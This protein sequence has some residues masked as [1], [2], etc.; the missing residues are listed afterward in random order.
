MLKALAIAAGLSFTALAAPLAAQDSPPPPV[1]ITSLTVFGD[2]LVDAGNIFTSTGGAVPSPSL[3]YFQGRFTNGFDYTDLLSIALFG[4][5]TVASLQGGTNFAFGGARATTTSGVPDLTEQLAFY[6]GYLA[7][8]NTVDTTGLFVLNFGG[9]DIFGAV[10][11]T[12][13]NTYADRS[14]FLMDAARTYADAVQTLSDLGANN[15]L[16]TG[17]PNATPDSALALSLEANGFLTSD[18]AGLSLDDTNVY[19]FSYLDFFARLRADPTQFGLPAD[20]QLTGSCLAAGAAP[21]CS[22][23]FS[24]DGVHPTA[25]VQRAVFGD[26]QR[27]FNFSAPVPEPATW[28]MLII[29]FAFIGGVMRRQ[30]AAMR[31]AHA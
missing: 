19:F 20:L 4:Q 16:I 22:N 17:F 14:A 10:Q 12:F 29:G 7:A 27:Q 31:P 25:A 5:P 11:G 30:A 1:P 24:F 9:N 18:L 26:I 3:G 2:S 23:F 6:S 21:G 15:I 13:P 28:M 8:G